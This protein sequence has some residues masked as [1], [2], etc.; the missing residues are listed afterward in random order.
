MNRITIKF[1]NLDTL[2]KHDMRDGDSPMVGVPAGVEN[3]EYLVSVE[4]VL[5]GRSLDGPATVEARLR[6][7]E[8]DRSPLAVLL[9]GDVL[10][11]PSEGVVHRVTV[12]DGAVVESSVDLDRTVG[13]G[14]NDVSNDEF[15]VPLQAVHGGNEALDGP[16][17]LSLQRTHSVLALGE[18]GSGKTEFIKLLLPQIEAAPDEP[19]VVFD[20]K[21]EYREWAEQRGD[22]V[23]LSTRDST[24]TWNLFR[25]VDRETEYEEIGRSLFAEAERRSNNPYFPK[26]ARQVFVALLKTFD[27][28]RDTPTNADLVT[29]CNAHDRT[30]LYDVLSQFDDLQSAAANLDPA[31]DNQAAGVYGSLQVLLS[32]VF[33]GEFAADGGFSVREYM[34]NPDGRTLVLD[35]P[36]REGKRVTAA[37]TLLLSRA[38]KHALAAPDR[39]AYFVLDEFAQIPRVENVETLVATGRSRNTQAVLG[40]QSVSQLEDAYGATTARSVLSGL[41]QEVFLRTGDPR[42]IDYVTDR[43]GGER[44]VT[45]DRRAESAHPEGNGASVRR[46]VVGPTVQGFDA[47]EGIVATSDGRTHVRLPMWDALGDRTRRALQARDQHTRRQTARTPFTESVPDPQPST[48][49]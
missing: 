10:A 18:P 1:L 2:S 27:R 24:R 39:N 44:H 45:A 38:I 25:E 34:E 30:G 35:Y 5:P 42:S 19:V 11:D 29:T 16:R 28:V 15:A 32:E 22:V 36:I 7:V 21:G 37:F 43:L 9:S 3:G 14:V 12:A 31:A 20:F 4:R 41:T 13:R 6:A 8:R 46:P 48:Q 23:R 40:L 49:D 17:L 26:A 47:G 33:T